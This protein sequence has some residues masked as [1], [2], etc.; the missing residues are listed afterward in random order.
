M[1]Y[2]LKNPKIT[3]PYGVMRNLFG[4]TK[5][6][7]GIDIISTTGDREVRAIKS[8]IYR[9]ANYDKD[10]FGNYVS[11]QHDDGTRAYYAHLAKFAYIP[12]NTRIEEGTVLGMEGSTG[13]S[14]GIHLHLELRDSPYMP[15]NHVDI[16]KYLGIQNKCGVVEKLDEEKKLG[17]TKSGAM[18]VVKEATGFEEKT[19]QYLDKYE[20]NFDLFAKLA[21]AIK[22]TETND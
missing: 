6:H 17:Y 19:M 20:Y 18:N 22:P 5:L 1:V 4:T 10:G 8:G 13:N 3:S 2:P 16:A 21:Y 7:K 9:G 14:T 12:K 15:R 11:V